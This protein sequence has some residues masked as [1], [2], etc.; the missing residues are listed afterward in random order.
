MVVSNSPISIA[1]I[2]FLISLSAGAYYT[3]ANTP[4]WEIDWIGQD[5]V[6]VSWDL[7]PQSLQ[8]ISPSLPRIPIVDIYIGTGSKGCPTAV[9]EKDCLEVLMQLPPHRPERRAPRPPIPQTG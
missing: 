5:P 7:L 4:C 3:Y 1:S 9:D 6:E 8:A 2:A